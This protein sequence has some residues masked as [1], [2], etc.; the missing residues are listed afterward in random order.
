MS[1]SRNLALIF[2]F[3][4]TLVPDSTTLFLNEHKIN[5]DEFW[6]KVTKELIPKGY[7]STLGFLRLFLD[8]IGPDKPLGCI[9]NKYLNE[10]GSTLDK[11]FFT[12]IKRLLKD[13]RETVN[14]YNFNIDF[15]IISGGL[16]EIIRGSK[17]VE[18]NFAGVY[19]C[20]LEDNGDPLRLMYIKRAINFT[21]KTRFLFEINKGIAPKNSSINPYLV[22]TDIHEEDRRI[23]FRNMIYVG[24]GLTDI[25][26]FSTVRKYGGTVFG[27]CDLRSEVKSKNA[28]IE[29]LLP[30]RTMGVY[31]PNYN[32]NSEL[33]SFIRA[34]VTKICTDIVVTQASKFG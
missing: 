34:A 26:C 30:N 7:D 32:K 22:N 11:R 28:F 9:T 18:K 31:K 14:N 15:F 33:G 5:T 20:K 21:E 13:L 27:I 29:F 8:N 4:D 17:F 3:D 1:V 23:P 25:P 10:W 19:G 2:D 24:D 6:S 16:E 12:G